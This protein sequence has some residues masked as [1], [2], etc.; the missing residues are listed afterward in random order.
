MD[1]IRNILITIDKDT[2]EMNV[3]IENMTNNVDTTLGNA[4]DVSRTMEQMSA[5][6]Q[7]IAASIHNI[8]ELIGSSTDAFNDVIEKIKEGNIFA[9]K[10]HEEAIDTGKEAIK[11]E[12]EVTAQVDEMAA[13][14]K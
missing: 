10:I 1:Y 6:M 7:E 14:V 12:D 2:K 3:A 4:D 8:D 9:A 5:T 13:V 11:T